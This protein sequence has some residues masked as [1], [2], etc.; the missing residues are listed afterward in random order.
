MTG[1]SHNS[2]SDICLGNGRASNLFDS[3]PRLANLVLTQAD[4]RPSFDENESKRK[5]QI[6]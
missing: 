6:H 5:I 2:E 1:R 4:I 3:D